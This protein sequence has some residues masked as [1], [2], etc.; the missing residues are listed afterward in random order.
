VV[1]FQPTAALAGGTTY[2]AT[3]TARDREGNA[4]ASPVTWS[5]T[6][7]SPRPAGC[8]C[9]I[10]DD[11][12]VPAVRASLDSSAVELG[13]K[14]RFDG[15]GAIMGIRFYKGAGNTGTHTGSLWSA[16]GQQLATGTF[17]GETTEGWQTLAFSVPIE[18]DANTTYVVSYYAPNGHYA[19][20]SGYFSP[21]GA[22]YGALHALRSGVDGGNAVYRY[23]SGGGFP[24]AS[25][26]ATNY[27]VDVIYRSGLNGDTTPPTLTAQTPD[28]GA[29][30]VSLSGVV[31]GTF[32]EPVDLGSAQFSLTDPGGTTL[33]VT[34]ALSTDQKTVTWTPT[35]PL[36][37]ATPYTA[38]VMIADVNG[39]AMAAPVTWSFTPVDT[40]TCPCSLFSAATVPTITSEN[41]NGAY[42]LGIRFTPAAAGTITGV[43]FYKGTGNTGTHTG[44]LWSATGQ[45]LATGT[46][47]NETATGWQ[48]L[49]FATPVAVQ[50]GTSYVASYTTTTGHYALDRG[51]FQR[52]AVNSPPLAAPGTSANTPN[53]VYQA[54]SGFPTATYQGNNYWVDVVYAS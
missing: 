8:P 29:S 21:S 5:F 33:A 36:A 47:S 12:T 14:V 54:G 46:F 10:W 2:T 31:T 45:L 30:G 41:D 37:A 49:T 4:L 19:A 27:W 38:S 22:D 13:T 35:A 20:N 34:P 26:N 52:T 39:N 17:T 28:A 7:G 53:G 51:Y 16:T 48:T 25:Y 32:S 18:V 50:A 44:S 15:K 23:G 43:R 24:T 9:T 6:T 40:Q 1:R 42:E 3:V 11:F